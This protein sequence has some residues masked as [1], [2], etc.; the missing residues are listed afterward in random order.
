MKKLNTIET[1][2]QTYKRL[3]S[4]IKPRKISKGGKMTYDEENKMWVFWKPGIN[5]T[6]AMKD[7]KKRL[8]EHRNGKNLS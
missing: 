3:K 2:E 4:K 8:N 1:S 7:L 5:A 6:N